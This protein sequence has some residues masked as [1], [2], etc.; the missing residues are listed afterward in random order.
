MSFEGTEKYLWI[1]F[2]FFFVIYVVVKICLSVIFKKA[3]EKRYKAFIPFYCRLVF[4][5]I[6]DLKKSLFYKT[7]IPFVNLYYYY[8][9][10]GRMLE[11]F[12]IGKKDAILYIL[13]PLYKFP[14]FVFKNPKYTLHL[15]DNTEQYFHDEKSLF[16]KEVQEVT[17]AEIPS[18]NIPVNQEQTH[19]MPNQSI[20]LN[21]TDQNNVLSSIHI[22][23]QSEVIINPTGYNQYSN[24]E[25]NDS[26]FTNASLQPDERKETIIEAKEEVKEEKAP[27]LAEAG[28][29]KVCPKCGTKLDNAAKVCFFCGTEIS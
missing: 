15:Y 25:A 28:R 19:Q 18:Q 27:I 1:L 17:P 11:V 7:L 13:L 21:N 22:P 14:E 4:I 8:I 26:V 10:I 12:N 29:P 20:I 16:E 23:N 6:L 24:S 9:I 5:D 2:V 3:G